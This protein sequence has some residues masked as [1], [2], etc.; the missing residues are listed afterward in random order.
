MDKARK[1]FILDALQQATAESK[2]YADRQEA[3][4]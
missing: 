1:D 3:Q 4:K 2:E